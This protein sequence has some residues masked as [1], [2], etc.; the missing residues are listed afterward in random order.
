MN[1]KGN[2]K[3]KPQFDSAYEFQGSYAKVE[4]NSKYYL[5][6][7]SG[8]KVMDFDDEY[9]SVE[10]ANEN[11]RAAYIIDDVLYDMKLN[12]ITDDNTIVYQNLYGYFEGI[13]ENDSIYSLM[14]EK[15][16]I[17]LTSN[18]EYAID[19]FRNLATGRY[20]GILVEKKYWKVISL[21]SVK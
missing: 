2:V 21:D 7:T 14:N 12:K 8:F 15:G 13:N 18:E 4:D 6:N 1:S 16:E 3:I 9:P 11:N 5:I 19:M 20:Y 17:L 10:F